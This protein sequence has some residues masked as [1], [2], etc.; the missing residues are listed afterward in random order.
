M[1]P[2]D[3]LDKYARL[4]ISNVAIIMI[5]GI[6]MV[7]SSSYIYAK[8]IYGTSLYFFLKQIM[9]SL[10]GVGLAYIVSKTKKDFW[11]K[12]AVGIHLLATLFLLFTLI[13]PLGDAVKGA[14]RW[15]NLFGLKFQP[16]EF[17]KVTIILSSICFFEQ[18]EKRQKKENIIHAFFLLLPLPIFMAQPDFGTFSI[19]FISIAF[20]CYLS[21]FPRRVF[22]LFLGAG[23]LATI[24]LLLS[25]PYRVERIFSFLDPWKNAKGSG[26][27]IIQSYLA[28][29]SGAIMGQGLGNSNEKLFYLP[30]AHNDFIFSVIGEETGLLGVV[31]VVA[32]F[33]FFLYIGFNM[34]LL[35]R[36]GYYRLLAAGLSFLVALQ[37]FLNMGVVLGLLPTKGLNLPFISY[38][39]SSLVANFFS[40]GLLLLC[41]KKSD[42]FPMSTASTLGS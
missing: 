21:D 27:Q 1:P 36:E 6:V 29:A 3:A 11:P 15:V 14:Y 16:G 4:L 28:F 25:R 17:V 32:S 30:E 10:L 20:V 23:I 2:A 8:E 37:A 18:F 12:Y 35:L 24:P 42:P 5:I 9:F 13:P 26:F 34:A 19:C 22:Y 38:G 33:A 31:V 39:G 7:Y 40:L 41:A